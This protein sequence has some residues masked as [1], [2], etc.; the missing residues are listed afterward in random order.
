[1]KYFIML[2]LFISSLSA[3]AQTQTAVTSNGKKV[4]LKDDNTWHYVENSK[5]NS[6]YSKCNLGAN[7]KE[8]SGNEKLRKQVALENNCKT[9]DIIFIHMNEGPNHG[10]YTL[11]VEGNFMKYKK[12]K[13]SFIRVDKNK[14][15]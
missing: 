15:N 3:F 10:I 14:R 11:C 6:Y 5:Q 4:L 7:F 2:G 8:S 13:N 12:I 1:M 9:S